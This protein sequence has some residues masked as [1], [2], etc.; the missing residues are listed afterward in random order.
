VILAEQAP[1][2]FVRRDIDGFF[3]LALDNLIQILLIIGLCQGVLG[4]SPELLYGRVL[5]AVQKPDCGECLL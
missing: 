2:W 4:F 1:R 5:P 3:G